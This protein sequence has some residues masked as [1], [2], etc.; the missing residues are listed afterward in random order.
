MVGRNVTG[1]VKNFASTIQTRSAYLVM[2]TV[3]L[4]LVTLSAL[5]D[6]VVEQQVLTVR[7][8]AETIFAWPDVCVLPLRCTTLH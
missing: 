1:R 2:L 5:G 6:N 3:Q 8:A 7:V 4:A